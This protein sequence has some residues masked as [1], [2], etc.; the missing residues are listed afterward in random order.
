M[1]ML[2]NVTYPW[3]A[4]DL[5]YSE[6]APKVEVDRRRKSTGE[7]GE[8]YFVPFVG[9]VDSGYSREDRRVEVYDGG[10]CVERDEESDFVPFVEETTSERESPT[11]LDYCREQGLHPSLHP[12]RRE[13]YRKRV[14]LE[15]FYKIGSRGG[16]KP[17][18][19]CAWELINLF[20][21]KYREEKKVEKG[22]KIR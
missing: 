18:Q 1:I 12:S 17:S 6:D 3:T 5:G 22:L 16:R 2:R 13:I 15:E 14:A 21:K 8:S 7:N 4:A 11:F 19:M 20:N 10:R 9:E